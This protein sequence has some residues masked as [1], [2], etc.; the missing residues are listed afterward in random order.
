MIMMKLGS[1]ANQGMRI[2]GVAWYLRVSPRLPRAAL[3]CAALRCAAA[4]TAMSP[5]L[6]LR[7]RHL[8]GHAPM[9]RPNHFIWGLGYDF[10][11]YEFRNDNLIV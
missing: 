11:D 6:A 4:P 3:R 7:L 1:R 10:A 8:A 5:L 2:T 9:Y